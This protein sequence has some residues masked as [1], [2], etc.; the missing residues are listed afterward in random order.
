MRVLGALNNPQNII[1]HSSGLYYEAFICDDIAFSELRMPNIIE[2]FDGKAV[3]NGNLVDGMSS[4]CKHQ[5]HP[6]IDLKNMD[7]M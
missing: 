6:Y 4:M 1:N 2:P 7:N 5:S 3:P